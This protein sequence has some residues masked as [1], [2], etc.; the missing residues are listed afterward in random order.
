MTASC[1][2]AYSPTAWASP[3]A[4]EPI[5]DDGGATRFALL[6]G[7]SKRPLDLQPP[8]II[9]ATRRTIDR[10]SGLPVNGTPVLRPRAAWA[11]V[12][13]LTLQATRSAFA[14]L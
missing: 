2:V 3:G 10:I 4:I 1:V 8:K 14:A 5:G 12:D 6:I 11:S 13:Q 7:A 9:D